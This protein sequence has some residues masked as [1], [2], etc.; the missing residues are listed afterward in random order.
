VLQAGIHPLTAWAVAGLS[1]HVGYNRPTENVTLWARPSRHPAAAPAKAF[2]A[3]CEDRTRL[4][5][6]KTAF[7]LI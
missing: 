2:S 6:V 7:T 3:S 4:Q 1:A 5:Q